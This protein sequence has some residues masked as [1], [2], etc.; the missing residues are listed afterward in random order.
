M[1][2]SSTYILN[3]LESTLNSLKM[4]DLVQNILDLKG[5]VVVDADP[6]KLWE[7]IEKLTENMNQF[8]AENNKLQSDTVIIKNVNRKL[9]E[10]IVILKTIRQKESNIAAET[11]H[12]YQAYQTG[13]LVSILE[14]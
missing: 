11:K 10:K 12:K 7:K 6:N 5:K 1:G 14:T 13:F 4:L 3:L 9:E 2:E 8:V